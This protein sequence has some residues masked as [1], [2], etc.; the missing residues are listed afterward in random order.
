MAPQVLTA[1]PAATAAAADRASLYGS[2]VIGGGSFVSAAGGPAGTGAQSGA[3]G[4]FLYRSNTTAGF[5]GTVSSTN[6]F[7]GTGIKHTNPFLASNAQAPE[8]P[9][10]IGGAETFGLTTLSPT[11]FPLIL[12]AAPAGSAAALYVT[13]TGP[14][15]YSTDFAG[16]DY[17]FFIN[18]STRNPQLPRV[19]SRVRDCKSPARAGQLHSRPI[20]RRR[21]CNTDFGHSCRLAGVCH[22]HPDRDDGGK[23]QFPSMGSCKENPRRV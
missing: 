21:W 9:S 11:A 18:L 14:G 4:R 19:W 20:I 2:V 13:H 8:I 3:S 16:F 5:T 15:V 12:A 6:T 23:L 17:L 10:L 1:A 22:S 7:S